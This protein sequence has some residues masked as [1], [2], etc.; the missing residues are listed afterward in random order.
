MNK[1]LILLPAFAI[2]T[3]AACKDTEKTDNVT[4]AEDTA[5]LKDK[6]G[7]NPKPGDGGAST[8]MNN[9]AF[10]WDG[11]DW[12]APVVKYGEVSDKDIEVRG[13][14]GY[15]IYS[16]GENVLFATG[17]A[18]IKADSKPRLDMVAAS[19]GAH[20]AGSHVGVYGFTDATGDAA[21]NKELS[22]KRAASVK[23]YLAGKGIA[24]NMISIQGMGESKPVADN[25]SAAG[26]AAN[27][28]VQIVAKK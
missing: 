26:K 12:Q 4:G 22:D 20:Y 23:A 9:T 15:G 18:D 21:A 27:R 19:I 25:N 8:D 1:K 11:L 13:N 17:S 5:V 28:R 3:L 16:L 7:T 6:N 2:L 24:D 10:S 14:E